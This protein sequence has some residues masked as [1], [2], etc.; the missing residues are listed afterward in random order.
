MGKRARSEDEA[1]AMGIGPISFE[2]SEAGQGR[3]SS[4]QGSN[5]TIL[6]DFCRLAAVVAETERKKREEQRREEELQRGLAE[7]RAMFDALRE[8][9]RASAEAHERSEAAWYAMM[10]EKRR[11]SERRWNTRLPRLR[12]EMERI[13]REYQAEMAASGQQVSESRAGTEAS[14]LASL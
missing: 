6:D 3:I 4:V 10:D 13:E 8:L 2:E 9:F 7:R 14:S 12:A 11:R 5:D 1:D